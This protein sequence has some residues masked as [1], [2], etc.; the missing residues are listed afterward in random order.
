[1]LGAALAEPER[2]QLTN[3]LLANT[4]GGARIRAG[5]PAGWRVADKTGSGGYGGAN[6][7]AVT[8]TD[9][10]GPI[11]IAILSVKPNVDATADNPLVAEAT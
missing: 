5:V 1:V 3:W 7:V 11:V 8:W 4:T 9:H 10:G 6:D 2:T